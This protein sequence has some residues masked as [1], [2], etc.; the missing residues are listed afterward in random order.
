MDLSLKLKLLR[1]ER[2]LTQA[3][4]AARSGVGVKTLSSF[5]TSKRSHAIKVVQLAAILAVY[6]MTI[7]QFDTWSPKDGWPEPL[8]EEEAPPVG[9]QPAARRE[10]VDPLKEYRHDDSPYP[11]PQSSLAHAM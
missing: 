7:G 3:E 5:E 2:G 4:V 10:P 1:E 9:T 6:G 11:S 8:P